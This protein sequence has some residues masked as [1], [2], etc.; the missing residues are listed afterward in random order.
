[1]QFYRIYVKLKRGGQAIT[2]S[3]SPEIGLAAIAQQVCSWKYT[4]AL[5]RPSRAAGSGDQAH[6]F[7]IWNAAEFRALPL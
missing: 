2:H 3:Q 5:L 4:F 7:H 1:M 6:S